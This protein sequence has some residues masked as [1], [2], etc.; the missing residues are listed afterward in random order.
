LARTPPLEVPALGVEVLIIEGEVAGTR[1]R[2]LSVSEPERVLGLLSA[3][4]LVSQ[5]EGA[6]VVMVHFLLVAPLGVTAASGS[7]VCSATCGVAGA[8][9]AQDGGM[10]RSATFE[11]PPP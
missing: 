8:L 3:F 7:S 1:E 4:F 6:R 11:A 10:N 2:H 9:A 5:A